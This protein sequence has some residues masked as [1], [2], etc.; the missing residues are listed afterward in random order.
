MKK[1]LM[2]SIISVFMLMTMVVTGFSS[3]IIVNAESTLP[4]IDYTKKGSIAISKK[5]NGVDPISKVVFSGVKVADIAQSTTGTRGIHFT[6]TAV[7]KEVFTSLAAKETVT[8]EELNSAIKNISSVDIAKYDKSAT[9]DINGIAMFANLDL[10]VYLV[11]ETNNENAEYADGKPAQI[12]QGVAPFLVMVPQ[13]NEDGDKWIYDRTVT[14]KNIVDDETLEKSVDGEDIVITEDDEI[15]A[16][17]GSTVWYTLTGSISRVTEASVYTKYLFTDK[18]TTG[19]TYGEKDD[20]IDDFMSKIVVKIGSNNLTRG[21]DYIVTMGTYS[22][23]TRISS[24]TLEFVTAGL[25]LLNQEALTTDGTGATTVTVEYPA[26]I[27]ERAVDYQSKNVSELVYQHEGASESKKRDDAELF[28]LALEII[29]LFDS[30]PVE[31]LPEGTNIDA[32]KV[33]FSLKQKNIDEQGNE[34]YK[35]IFAKPIPGKA[36]EYIADF[37]VESASNGYVQVFACNEKGKVLI[38]GLPKGT[39]VITELTTV[40][41]YSL[42]AK[43]IEVSLDKGKTELRSIEKLMSAE[44]MQEIISAYVFG[45]VDLDYE[46]GIELEQI[47][48]LSS[49]N[50]DKFTANE[51]NTE[52]TTIFT[53]IG[54]VNV[55]NDEAPAFELPSTGGMGTYIYTIV[56]VLLMSAASLLYITLNKR[57]RY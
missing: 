31:D 15:T 16:A 44:Q 19:L 51:V 6:L 23:E 36:G 9:S 5:A 13:T 42:L 25:M 40:D 54:K 26:H 20:T 50:N 28:P 46:D 27:N 55:N 47:F 56:G 2:K 17:I 43:D 4:T 53:N 48:A 38:Y 39:Y 7:G 49:I 29:K 3:S 41:G 8:S 37:S 22:G 34:S 33:T 57:T 1:Q 12:V 10:G 52:T 24:F 45:S 32:T 30:T 35:D 21:K 11:E 14:A 18:I